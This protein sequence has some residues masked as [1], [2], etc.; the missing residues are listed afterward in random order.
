MVAK[1]E[2]ESTPAK[3]RTTVERKSER[4][5][6]VTRIFNAPARNRERCGPPM[7]AACTVRTIVEKAGAATSATR[8]RRIIYAV[9]LCCSNADRHS[10][11]RPLHVG[12]RVRRSRPG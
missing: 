5:L 11:Q 8:R 7:S 2:I 6:V 1:R 4:E 12:P 3:N 10:D 9:W